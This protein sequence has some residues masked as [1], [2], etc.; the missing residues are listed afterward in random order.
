MHAD[1]CVV[2]GATARLRSSLRI[3]RA[4]LN[5]IKNLP[6]RGRRRGATLPK[7][8]NHMFTKMIL[9]A[10]VTIV[11]ATATGAVAQQM[12]NDRTGDHMF[13]YGAAAASTGPAPA[14]V[15]APR[16]PARLHAVSA[17]QVPIDRTS[18]HMIYYGPLAQ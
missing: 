9:P 15:R 11:M 5:R 10:A 8:S 16:H 3:V 4:G 13:S 7:G 1:Q 6:D 17:P 18:D 12:P 14:A 2:T